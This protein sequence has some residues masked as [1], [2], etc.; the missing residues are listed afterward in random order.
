MTRFTPRGILWAEQPLGRV[1]DSE[2]A[3]T[4]GCDR[5]AVSSARRVRRIPQCDP[6]YVDWTQQPL[7]EET[8][9]EIAR[10]VGLTE[11]GVAAARNRRGVAPRGRAPA[12]PP[13]VRTR[14]WIDWS[15]W[16][17]G[18]ATDTEVA[19]MVGVDRGSVAAARARR[20][21]PIWLPEKVCPCGATFRGWSPTSRC[22]SEACGQALYHWRLRHRTP[23]LEPVAVALAALNREIKRRTA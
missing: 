14:H 4:L 20:Y 21:I 16:P 12:K 22:C 1:P 15:L 10:R 9:A 2:I 13:I 5:G 11:N 3:R 18:R 17:L 6:G 23:E 7:G 8:D 19:R